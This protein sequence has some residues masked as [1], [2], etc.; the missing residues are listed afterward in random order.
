M[1]ARHVLVV[2]LCI[3]GPTFFF[4]SQRYMKKKVAEAGKVEE[5]K[6]KKAAVMGV[7]YPI[8]GA[9]FI[10]EMLFNWNSMPPENRIL[11]YPVIAVGVALIIYGLYK[12]WRNR[13]G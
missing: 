5:Y 9:L 2:L 13:L 6:Q 8:V 4:W 11:A 12:I 1:Q 10:G 7:I 3:A